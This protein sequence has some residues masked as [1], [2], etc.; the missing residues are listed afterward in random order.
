VCGR[1]DL[2]TPPSRL[3]RLLHAQL[4]PGV[5]PEGT[6]RWNLPPTEGVLALVAG[7]RQGAPE[8][9]LASFRWGLVPAWAK[10]ASVG[11]RMINARAETLATKPAYRDAFADRRCLVV[12]DGFSSG[13]HPTPAVRRPPA[14]A[15]A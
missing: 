5:D 1:I 2:H 14:C 6:P 12:A 4:A 7:R 3:A 11:N 15:T 9:V 10:D 8:R 13:G